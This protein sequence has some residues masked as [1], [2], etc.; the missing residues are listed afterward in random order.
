MSNVRM[1]MRPRRFAS[2][3]APLSSSKTASACNSKASAN[4]SRSPAPILFCGVI[5]RQIGLSN[6]QPCGMIDN[7]FLDGLWGFG[8]LKVIEHGLRDDD[9]AKQAFKDISLFDLDQIT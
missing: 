3:I 5:E 1:V 2:T 6:L 9:S 4:A 8:A 7:P